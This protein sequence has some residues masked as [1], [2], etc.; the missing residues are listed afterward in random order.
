M[1]QKKPSLV[2]FCKRPKLNQGKQRLAEDSSAESALT[3]AKALL[4]CALEDARNWQGAVVL[5][6]SNNDD[7]E[8][9]KSLNLNAHV[10]Y[11]LPLNQSGNLGERL[12]FIDTELRKQGHQQLVFIGTDA[13][14]LTENHYQEIELALKDND[15]ALSHADDGG[16]V[17][18]A[19]K[20]PW[21][22]LTDLPWSTEKLSLSLSQLCREK[23]LSVTYTL[24]GY[25]IDY[26]ADI[27]KLL[28]DLQT[29]LRPARQALLL[30][31]EQTFND[32]TLLP[33]VTTHA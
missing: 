17:I 10:I 26:M 11:Q 23:K 16:V 7:M 20:A 18:M 15:I 12:N 5:A 14:M 29:D 9:A 21:P 4:D 8:W 31:L 1:N 3:I 22:N 27:K 6:C 25:D 24:S 30:T 32:L 19:N 13:P 28:I 2:I 33:K